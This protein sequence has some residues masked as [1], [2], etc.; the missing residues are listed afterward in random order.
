MRCVDGGRRELSRR[1]DGDAATISSVLSF[2][3][4]FVL[5]K[6]SSCSVFDLI[7]SG[8]QVNHARDLSW[9]W[10]FCC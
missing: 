7:L 9:V 4:Y 3:F 6:G 10:C 8:V 2:P 1:C 5:A